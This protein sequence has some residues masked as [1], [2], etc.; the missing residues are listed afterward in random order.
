MCRSR[1]SVHFSYVQKKFRIKE[2]KELEDAFTKVQNPYVKY[3]KTIDKAKQSYY[4]S[5][6]DAKV[7]LKQVQHALAEIPKLNHRQVIISGFHAQKYMKKQT[8]KRTSEKN[9]Q[10]GV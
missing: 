3:L 1:F 8:L 10:T 9:H 7:V 2:Q 5:C 6:D 4:K